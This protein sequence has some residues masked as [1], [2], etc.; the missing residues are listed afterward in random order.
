MTSRDE[1]EAGLRQ[2]F[3]EVLH[4]DATQ[5]SADKRL[6]EDFGV[7]S[8]AAARLSMAMEEH[9]EVELAIADAQFMTTFG[10]AVERVWM[11]LQEAP[12]SLPD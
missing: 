12:G 11:R 10:A 3:S 8:L 1:V 7:N 2:I 9:F 4:L 6:V 5:I